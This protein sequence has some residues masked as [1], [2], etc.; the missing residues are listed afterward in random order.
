M[1]GNRTKRIFDDRVDSCC[2]SHAFDF[3][4]QTYRRDIGEVMY[5]IS[6]P[7][8]FF[9]R[10]WGGFRIGFSAHGASVT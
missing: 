10:H 1:V 6:A 2:G 7:N 3:L 4:T 5:D 9:G 8:Y